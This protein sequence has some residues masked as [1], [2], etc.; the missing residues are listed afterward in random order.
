[1]ARMVLVNFNSGSVSD[2]T[3][4]ANVNQAMPETGTVFQILATK[5]N[6]PVDLFTFS[7][8][9]YEAVATTQDA[10]AAAQLVNIFPNPYFG[11]NSAEINPV[12]RFMTLTHLPDGAII[13]IF[14]L[15][16]DVV[17]TIDDATRAEQGTLGTGT[18]RW[19]LRNQ[20]DVPVASGMYLMHVDMGTLGTKILK[21][22]VFVPEE[23]LDKF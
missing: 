20:S 8:A 21:A 11:Q 7:T 17:K 6:Q 23:R 22:A 3:F 2:P 1:M 10:Q 19:D 15:A 13:R 4:P 18:A 5:T 14:T 9:G 16:G 12:E